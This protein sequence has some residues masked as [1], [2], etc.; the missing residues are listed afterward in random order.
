MASKSQSP[1]SKIET[2]ACPA[3]GMPR[4]EWPDPQGVTQDE[5]TFCCQACADEDECTCES[6]SEAA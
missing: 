1:E 2:G 3:C 5:K 4:N 6:E